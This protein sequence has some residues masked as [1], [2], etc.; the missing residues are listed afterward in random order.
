MSSLTAGDFPA[1][2]R[3][4]HGVEPFPWQ[5][6]LIATVLEQAWPSTITLPT[7]SGKTAVLDIAT[8]ALAAQASRPL[9]ERTS[10]RRIAL[11]VDR[12]VVVDEAH[13]R[14]QRIVAAITKADDD[15]LRRVRDAL[16]ALSGDNQHPIDHAALRGGIYKESRWA[17]SPAQP[18]LLCSTV[19]QVG[20][21]LLF[22]GYGVSNHAWPVHAGLIGR[23][24]CRERV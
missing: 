15:V 20:S 21:R 7:A 8:F 3:A 24:S 11:V 17:R 10:P 16:V 6:R 14:A 12:R 9:R 23:A 1:Y 19:D 2:F 18:V 5:R 13:H 22:R 4:I